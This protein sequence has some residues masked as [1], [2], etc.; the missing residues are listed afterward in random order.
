MCLD[1]WALCEGQWL[2]TTMQFE[3]AESTILY[4]VYSLM[5]KRM[6]VDHLM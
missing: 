6:T 5:V 2:E 3:S 1:N 4:G